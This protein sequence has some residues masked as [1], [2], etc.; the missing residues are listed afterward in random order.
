MAG[1]RVPVISAENLALLWRPDVIVLL[2]VAV[3]L[4][5]YLTGVRRKRLT[6]GTWP[7]ARVCWAIIA[8]TATVLVLN[9]GV[10]TYDGVVWSVTV[11]QQAVTSMVI[12]LAIVLSRPWDLFAE[13]GLVRRHVGHLTS[14]PGLVLAGYAAWSAGCLLT[15]VA[16]WSV[17][18]HAVLMTVRVGDILV[19]TAVF[20]VL[21]TPSQR[22]GASGE[23]TSPSSIAL[24]MAW[25]AIEIGIAAAL[26][27]G[28]AA[29][30]RP[31][32]SQLNLAWIEIAHNERTAA[33][34]HLAI[35][36]A[37]LLLVAAVPSGISTQRGEATAHPRNLLPTRAFETSGSE[38]RSGPIAPGSRS[39]S[40]MSSTSVTSDRHR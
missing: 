16:L 28:G 1:H 8:T 12:P 23:R 36:I 19:G 17:S 25:F 29:S 9:S 5:G 6:G 4:T 27:F 20:T 15:P 24:L 22:R 34:L 37:V 14:R 32:F 38:M 33:I 13:R 35:A 40:P 31:W 39:E 7:A 2:L 18:N 30:A 3:A 21:L 11:T 26:L 10:A